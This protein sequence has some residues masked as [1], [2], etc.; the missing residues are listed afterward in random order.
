MTKMPTATLSLAVL[1][2]AIGLV[3]FFAIFYIYFQFE[4]K[5][6][7]DGSYLG[8]T[9]GDSKQ[10]AY[11]KVPNALVE[12][13]PS[14]P[15]IFMEIEV[16]SAASKVISMGVGRH[17]MV[18]SSLEEFGFERFRGADQWK[19]YIGASYMNSLTLEFCDDRLCRISRMQK[20]FEIP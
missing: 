14:D 11:E 5:Q 9:I 18:Q 15:R 3:L 12:L 2:S 13:N 7:T 6:I 19:F 1:A 4:A 17:A 8:L 20:P 10:M 16:D